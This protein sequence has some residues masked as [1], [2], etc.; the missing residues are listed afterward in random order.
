MIDL[1]FNG[2]TLP[3]QGQLGH[4]K[5]QHCDFWTAKNNDI[6]S[7]REIVKLT[8]H[9]Y[10]DG[11]KQFLPT[12]ITNSFSE[13]YYSLKRVRDY[14]E[15]CDKNIEDSSQREMAHIPGVH[16]E[17]GFISKLGI[18]PAEFAKEMNLTNV[19]KLVSKFPGLIKMWTICPELDIDGEITRFL[20]DKGIL[21]S[22]GH[23]N[24]SYGTAE[25][26]FTRNEDAG[27]PSLVTHLF[28]AM[29]T[30]DGFHHRKPETFA[31]L[32]NPDLGKAGLGY[33]AYMNPKVHTMIICGSEEDG[34][35]HVA[36]KLV[37]MT[38]D[39]KDKGP[40]TLSLVTDAVAYSQD[41]IDNNQKESFLRGGRA[42]LKKHAENASRAGLSEE[43]LR[44]ATEVNPAFLLALAKK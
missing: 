29:N 14:K 9:L 22:F 38:A 40:G 12:I 37:K 32:D 41:E 15:S 3:Y 24:A 21:V 26:A 39:K 28:N 36:P 31:K 23:S 42:T 8:R 34:D 30:V 35:L 17:G 33:A 20:Q 13:I 43:Q 27:H 6:E 19:K 4:E 2:L 1:H 25:K 44:K 16:I 18:H 7:I 10:N 5:A 11:V